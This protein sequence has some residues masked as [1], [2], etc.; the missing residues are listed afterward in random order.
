MDFAVTEQRFSCVWVLDLN[1]VRFCQLT[2]R[3]TL[4]EFDRD[5]NM[6]AIDSTGF[7]YVEITSVIRSQLSSWHKDGST[8]RGTHGKRN[9]IVYIDR[10]IP[11]G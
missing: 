1:P 2:E 9:R 7:I 6:E 5:F 3:L 4:V 8:E 10:D 11:A